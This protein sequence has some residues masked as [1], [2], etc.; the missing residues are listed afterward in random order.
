[1]AE[2][3][4][5]LEV[6][7]RNRDPR[8]ACVLVVDV[9]GSMAGEPIRE[10]SRGYEQFVEELNN[11]P[12]ARKRAEVAVVTFGS[13]ASLTV[14][15]QEARNLTPQEFIASGTTNMAAGINMALDIIEERKQGYRAAGLEYFRPWM[16]LLTDG[17]PDPSGFDAAVTRV[18]DAQSAKKVT[19]FAVGVGDNVNFEHLRRLSS[20][21]GP[22][23][24]KGLDFSS[25]FAW[26][27]SSM[28]RVSMSN[29]AH[30]DDDSP[31]DPN[32]MIELAPPG[33][34]KIA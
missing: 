27:S 1:V 11:D 28:S 6:N 20:E 15:F 30:A 22:L 7:E 10:L 19:L 34:G 26:L 17:S 5:Q 23:S 8:A 33:W 3:P 14:P 12:L 21:R 2:M 13:G 25:M 9:S 4:L 16:F 29:T 24:L 18:L 31:S 32:E